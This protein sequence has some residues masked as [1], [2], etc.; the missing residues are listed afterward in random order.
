MKT[1]WI[2]GVA[3]LAGLMTAAPPAYATLDARPAGM[4]GWTPGM[5]APGIMHLAKV[6][7][8]KGVYRTPKGHKPQPKSHGRQG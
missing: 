1:V 2:L 7:Y 8:D 4:P 3:A 5:H 6:H